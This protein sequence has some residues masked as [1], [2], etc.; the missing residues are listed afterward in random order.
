[1]TM[2]WK[3]LVVVWLSP[4][5]T[6]L[7]QELNKVNPRSR[8]GTSSERTGWDIAL[9]VFKT[10]WRRRRTFSFWDIGEVGRLAGCLLCFST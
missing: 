9:K 2:K 8:G 10:A 7:I 4:P 1:M 6:I 5:N 3:N